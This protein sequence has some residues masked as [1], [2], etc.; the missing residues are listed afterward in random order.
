MQQWQNY[1][2]KAVLLQGDSAML[3]LFFGL[4]F[5]DNIHYKFIKVA[6]LRELGFRA[7]NIPAQNRI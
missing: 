6:K 5:A 4:K 1:N 3:Q 2:K 7:P